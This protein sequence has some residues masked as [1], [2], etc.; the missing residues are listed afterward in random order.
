MRV[1]E[2][3]RNW[4]GKPKELVAFLTESIRKNE[5]LFSQL[6]ENFENWF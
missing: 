6:I 1:I 2:E 3:I 5:K 4:E